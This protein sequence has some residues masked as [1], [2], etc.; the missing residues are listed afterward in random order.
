M[1]TRTFFKVDLVS[2]GNQRKFWANLPLLAFSLLHI[3]SSEPDSIL[4]PALQEIKEVQMGV[5]GR[6]SWAG[7]AWAP[8]KD[9]PKVWLLEEESRGGLACSR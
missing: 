1:Y 7:Q 2:P 6:S 9:V 8:L 4:L 3:F 5:L